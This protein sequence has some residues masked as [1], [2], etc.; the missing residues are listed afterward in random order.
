MSYLNPPKLQVYF[1]R[2]DLEAS[3]KVV[4]AFRSSERELEVDVLQQVH[5]DYCLRVLQV[6][7]QIS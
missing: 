3:G 6:V 5:S 7:N 2:D 1:E 4:L